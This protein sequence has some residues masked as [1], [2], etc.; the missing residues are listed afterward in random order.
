MAEYLVGHYQTCFNLFERVLSNVEE[1][2]DFT[3]VHRSEVLTF[4]GRCLLKKEKYQEC[5]DFLEKN[6]A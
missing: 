6:D 4:M 5:I 1:N 2:K 3:Q